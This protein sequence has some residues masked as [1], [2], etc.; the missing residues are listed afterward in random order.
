MIEYNRKCLK[1][2][3]PDKTRRGDACEDFCAN[4]FKDEYEGSLVCGECDNY[5]L[6]EDE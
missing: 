6:P 1:G 3:H 4:K 5:V 2:H